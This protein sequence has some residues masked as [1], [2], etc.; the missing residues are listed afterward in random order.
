M[1]NTG[2]VEN[3]QSLLDKYVRNLNQVPQEERKGRYKAAFDKIKREI[4]GAAFDLSMSRMA[5]PFMFPVATPEDV[6]NEFHDL[7]I[8]KCMKHRH[9]LWKEHDAS[10]LCKALEGEWDDLLDF[11]SEHGGIAR[12]FRYLDNLSPE[13]YAY[14]IG[15]GEEIREEEE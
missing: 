11:V 15:K 12:P 9:F 10:A 14:Y 1:S 2:L 4:A 13:D 8:N 3:L 6:T 5:E 7:V